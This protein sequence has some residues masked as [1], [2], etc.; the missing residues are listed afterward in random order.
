[1]RLLLT[2]DNG[3]DAEGLGVLRAAVG[4]LGQTAVLAPGQGRSG[5]GRS[6][7]YHGEIHVRKVSNARLGLGHCGVVRA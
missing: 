1:M 6:V 5:W 3:I 2:N 7:T 4:G